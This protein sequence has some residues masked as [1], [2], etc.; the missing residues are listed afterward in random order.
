MT[1]GEERTM[2]RVLPVAVA[3]AVVALAPVGP[4]SAQGDPEQGERVFNQCRACHTVGEGEPHR[5][6][7]N[8]HGV[9]GR[10]A[11]SAEGFNYSSA[12][13]E[14]NVVWDEGTL[15]EYLADPRA[16]IP[17]NRM[18]FPGLRDEGQRADVIAYLRQESQ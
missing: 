6:G 10:K 14:A 18:A 8:L 7:P 11:G 15:S 5:V 16:F 3:A 12:M 2:R 13:Q 4:A 1:S 9:V 17:G